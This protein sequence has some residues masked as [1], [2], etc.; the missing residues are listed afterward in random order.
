MKIK[1]CV[2]T[3]MIFISNNSKSEV[4]IGTGSDKYSKVDACIEAK[5][6]AKYNASK[7]IIKFDQC[8]CE[9]KSNGGYYCSVDAILA[10]KYYLIEKSRGKD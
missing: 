4:Q 7:E 2:L 9:E 6:N 1:T 3:L 10:S 8:D 5:R